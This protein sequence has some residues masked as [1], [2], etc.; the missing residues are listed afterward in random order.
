M[1]N[2]LSN[3]IMVVSESHKPLLENLPEVQKQLNEYHQLLEK[4]KVE[5]GNINLSADKII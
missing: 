2:E 1:L 5:T 4:Q 3:I